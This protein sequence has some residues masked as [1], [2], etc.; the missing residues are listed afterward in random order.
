MKTKL[1]RWQIWKIV[2]TRQLVVKFQVNVTGMKR[3][4]EHIG[5]L[6][7]QIRI[8]DLQPRSTF[9][10]ESNK[11]SDAVEKIKKG[12]ITKKVQNGLQLWFLTL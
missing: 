7:E 1:R 4:K 2:N 9:T 5:S 3:L 10:F 8:K 6:K 12:I 11:H